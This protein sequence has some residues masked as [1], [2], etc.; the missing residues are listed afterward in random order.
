M[1]RLAVVILILF[2]TGIAAADIPNQLPQQFIVHFENVNMVNTLT[3][4]RVGIYAGFLLDGTYTLTFTPGLEGDPW[5]WRYRGSMNKIT[6][7]TWPGLPDPITL[8]GLE[9]VFTACP[10]E[11]GG[12]VSTL[13]V[14]SAETSDN[15]FPRIAYFSSDY[16]YFS[17][18]CSVENLLTGPEAICMYLSLANAGQYGAA[19]FERCRDFQYF[20]DFASAWVNP[21]SGMSGL[22]DLTNRWLDCGLELF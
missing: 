9:I 8:T 17:Y 4:C 13:K 16:F 3:Y 12:W 14:T 7:V 21:D 15:R 18:D 6:V 19:R 2:M 5:T 10:D 1:T 22:V 20:A 11:Y